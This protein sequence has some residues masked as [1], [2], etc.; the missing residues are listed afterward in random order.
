M[1]MGYVEAGRYHH[2]IDRSTLKQRNLGAFI[3]KDDGNIF[4]CQ[5]FNARHCLLC[6][7]R[8]HNGQTCREYQEAQRRAAEEEENA[9]RRR[10]E[11]ETAS[12]E[13]VKKMSRPCPKCGVNIDMYTGCDHVTCELP[14][15]DPFPLFLYAIKLIIVSQRPSVSS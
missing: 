12:A 10:A 8:F 4:S 9:P 2:D 6:D 3:V 14:P 1:F 11:E 15:T 7:V 5:K 13:A